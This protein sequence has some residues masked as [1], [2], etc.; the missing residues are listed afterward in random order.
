MSVRVIVEVCLFRG[1]L[2]IIHL[3]CDSYALACGTV[4]N[5]FLLIYSAP[6]VFLLVFPL[7]IHPPVFIFFVLLPRTSS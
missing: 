5:P 1:S 2:F 3:L 7:F 4:E 6:I